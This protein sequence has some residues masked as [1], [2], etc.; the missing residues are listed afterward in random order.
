MDRGRGSSQL[1]FCR[2]EPGHRKL[3]STTIVIIKVKLERHFRV[4]GQIL[5]NAIQEK[6]FELSKT[7]FAKMPHVFIPLCYCTMCHL[8]PRSVSLTDTNQVSFYVRSAPLG[9]AVR[10]GRSSVPWLPFALICQECFAVAIAT[11]WVLKGQEQQCSR[12]RGMHDPQQM[13]E[14]P[15]LPCFLKTLL[16]DPAQKEIPASG[17]G[18]TLM[19]QLKIQK[20]RPENH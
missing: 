17:R 4:V 13:W 10:G 3:N 12:S 15:G 2:M 6:M 20:M 9:P 19:E 8:I 11:A 7:S 18:Q 14:S 1:S 5:Q 16:I